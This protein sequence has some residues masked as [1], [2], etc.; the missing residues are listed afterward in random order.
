MT[1]ANTPEEIER[2]KEMKRLR[3]E[4]KWTLQKIA[5]Q[6]GISRERVRQLIGNTGTRSSHLFTEQA[7][8]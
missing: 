5:S 8:A 6:Y 7:Q 1:K 2:V 3:F 4:L